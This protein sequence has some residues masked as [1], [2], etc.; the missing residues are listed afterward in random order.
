MMSDI[1]AGGVPLA[2]ARSLVADL[3][4]DMPI[5]T[6]TESAAPRKAG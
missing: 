2:R 3:D 5:A 4:S 6:A 1:V